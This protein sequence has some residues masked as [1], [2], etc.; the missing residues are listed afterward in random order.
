[1][2]ESKLFSEKVRNLCE[3]RKSSAHGSYCHWRLFLGISTIGPTDA[4]MGWKGVHLLGQLRAY[5]Q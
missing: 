3:S 2:N 5:A 4:T 1:M